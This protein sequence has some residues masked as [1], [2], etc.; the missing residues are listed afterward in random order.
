MVTIGKIKQYMRLDE[1]LTDDDAMIQDLMNSAIEYIQNSTGKIYKDSHIYDMAIIQLVTHWY[2][3][4]QQTAAK[5]GATYELPFTVK[6]IMIHIANSR[7][8]ADITEGNTP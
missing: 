7:H 1:D 4:R 2:D 6:N 5:S 3:N 8:Y